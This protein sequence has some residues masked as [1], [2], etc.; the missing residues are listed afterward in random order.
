ML[1]IKPRIHYLPKSFDSSSMFLGPTDV[2]PSISSGLSNHSVEEGGT[3][4]FSCEVTGSP[5]PSVS[6][7]QQDD[8][9]PLHNTSVVMI[10]QSGS[11]SHLTLINVTRAEHGKYKCVA[12]SSIGKDFK[13]AELVVKGKLLSQKKKR[14]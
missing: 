14:Q 7:F 12:T 13:E 11:T 10:T 2:L 6:W 9:I 4:T 1:G 3:V 8:V 5:L